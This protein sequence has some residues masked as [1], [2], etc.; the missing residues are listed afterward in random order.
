VDAVE[1][2]L[3]DAAVQTGEEGGA[4]PTPNGRL[5]LEVE[6]VEHLRDAP[7]FDEWGRHRSVG[8]GWP[9]LAHPGGRSRTPGDGV[10]RRATSRGGEPR[11][12]R[13]IKVSP[14]RPLRQ[15]TPGARAAR[16]RSCGGTA[17]R[18]EPT[19]RAG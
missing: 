2:P 7:G 14:V 18:V 9:P 13:G 5:D 15:P 17:R 6:T 4:A 11:R 10:A 1:H 8:R 12:R 3:R 19:G 16:H